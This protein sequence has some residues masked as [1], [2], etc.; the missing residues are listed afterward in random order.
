MT[1]RVRTN[2]VT[3]VAL[4]AFVIVGAAGTYAAASATTVGACV[5]HRGGRLYVAHHCARHDRRLRWSITGP[6]GATGAAGPQGAPGAQ[7][8][9]GAPGAPGAPGSPGQ[10]ATKL[11]AQVRSDGTVNASGSPVTVDHFGTGIYLV[12]F[13]Q[14]VTHCAAFANQ[15]GVPVFTTPGAGTPAAEGY[16]ARV[17]LSSAGADFAPGFPSADTVA[18]ATF[19]G[20]TGA[21]TS[22][23]V[24]VM[25]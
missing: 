11:F 15:G 18:I 8:D 4:A 20:S 2:P 16:G 24:V 3:A 12:N 13:G 23:E 25:C 6:R 5:G 19:S 9:P 10:S 14:D 7:G 22:F 17:D 1:G 21:D